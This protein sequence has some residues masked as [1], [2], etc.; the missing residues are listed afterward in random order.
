MDLVEGGS[1]IL[2][3]DTYTKPCTL[4]HPPYVTVTR[5][6]DLLWH[7]DSTLIERYCSLLKQTPYLAIALLLTEEALHQSAGEQKNADEFHCTHPQ[8]AINI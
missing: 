8:I 5:F 4:A 7:V 3:V 1:V 6:N 2:F